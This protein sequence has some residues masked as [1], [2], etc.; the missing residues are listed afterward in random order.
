[1]LPALVERHR[2]IAIEF[3][4]HG[5]T[6]DIEREPS[7]AAFASDVVGVLDHLDIDR[8][9]F[10]GFSLGGLVCLELLTAHP[11]RVGR[12]V[13]ASAHS[14]QEG[15]YEEI[16]DPAGTSPRLPTAEEFRQMQEAYR[17]V[18]PDPDHFEAFL[19]RLSPAVHG[20]PGWTPDQLRAVTA[21]VLIVIGDRDFVRPEHALQMQSSIPDAQLAILPGTKHT[22]VTQRAEI[23]PM[24][25]RFLG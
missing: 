16:T 2:V 22:E 8:A 17:R 15:Y 23:L 4:G 25:E 21:S 19:G 7:I 12:A 13:L 18:A 1:V 3:Q 10:L 5:H 11:Q 24:L 6:A 14:A 20:M 9:D